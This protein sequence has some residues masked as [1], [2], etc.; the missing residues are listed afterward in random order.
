MKK[1]GKPFYL[2]CICGIVLIQ[3]ALINILP[4]HKI[5]FIDSGL[6]LFYIGLVLMIKDKN[7]DK[8]NENNP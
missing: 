1:F 3:S 7:I 4:M 8:E 5:I 2:I 6:V